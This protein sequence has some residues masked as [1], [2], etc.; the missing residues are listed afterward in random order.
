MARA[1]TGAAADC[2]SAPLPTAVVA[3][4]LRSEQAGLLRPSCAVGFSGAAG[5]GGSI[6]STT[7]IHN[8]L[9]GT[10]TP[11]ESCEVMRQ[12]MKGD[13]CMYGAELRGARWGTGD[14]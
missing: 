14:W 4:W 10:A 7:T 1:W 13:V 11:T 6:W 5:I 12:R 9:K 2:G 8:G 3:V